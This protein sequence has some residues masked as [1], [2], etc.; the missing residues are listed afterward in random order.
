MNTPSYEA[1]QWTGSNLA[2][3]QDFVNLHLGTATR[4]YNEYEN[5][6]LFINQYPVLGVEIPANGYVVFGPIYGSDVTRGFID[7][8]PTAT[9][10]AAQYS[11]V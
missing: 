2:A 5:G 9:Q 3:V 11:V 4:N 7:N 8:G 1:I 6:T 10:F